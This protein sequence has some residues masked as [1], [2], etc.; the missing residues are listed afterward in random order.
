MSSFAGSQV[1]Q[2]ASVCQEG[3][4]GEFFDWKQFVFLFNLS[5]IPQPC[6]GFCVDHCA[7]RDCSAGV[8]R[9]VQELPAAG[10]VHPSRRG[11][12]GRDR[13]DCSPHRGALLSR[14]L[15]PHAPRSW[16]AEVLTRLDSTRL[17][18]VAA[19][20]GPAG[21]CQARDW[22]LNG[23]TEIVGDVDRMVSVLAPF[24]SNRA[25]VRVTR[26]QPFFQDGSL[27]C[28]REEAMAVVGLRRARESRC[29]RW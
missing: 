21:R 10:S 19:V 17:A 24:G 3:H 15:H 20:G 25:R 7:G 13:Q 27:R 23:P 26:E 1:A 5:L 11:Q 16:L 12:D 8:R 29:T 22:R 14:S 6:G 28:E 2:A 4:E 9:D 18:R